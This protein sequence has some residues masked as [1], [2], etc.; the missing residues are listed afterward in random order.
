MGTLR[1]HVL[2]N[3]WMH[4][5]SDYG[6]SAQIFPLGPTKT[7]IK[8]SWIVH[9]VPQ[10]FSRAD[11]EGCRRRHRLQP[12]P[13]TSV[14]GE[15]QRRRLEDMRTQYERNTEFSLQT[16]TVYTGPLLLRVGYSYSS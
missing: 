14:L 8:T 15:D 13:V 5:S 2:P 16:G 10:I 4:L 11:R 1:I 3:Y 6:S 12:K 7:A 9:K